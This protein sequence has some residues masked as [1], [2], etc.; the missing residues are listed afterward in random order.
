MRKGSHREN[1]ISE[2]GLKPEIDEN[3]DSCS[4]KYIDSQSQ[5]NN[6]TTANGKQNDYLGKNLWQNY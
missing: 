4:T 3:S 5:D 6:C 1:K 2:N